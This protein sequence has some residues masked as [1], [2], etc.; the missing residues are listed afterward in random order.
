MWRL[1]LLAVAESGTHWFGRRGG[2]VLALVEK[3]SSVLD[4]SVLESCGFLLF[5]CFRSNF[6]SQIS[7]CFGESRLRQG[8]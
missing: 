8:S 6:R 4:A 1:V 7:P 5:K 2:V 3:L